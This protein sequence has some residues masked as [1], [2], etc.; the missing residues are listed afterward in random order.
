MA[1]QTHLSLIQDAIPLRYDMTPETVLARINCFKNNWQVTSLGTSRTFPHPLL[2]INKSGFVH[3][4]GVPKPLFGEPLTGVNNE[5][6][7]F[8]PGLFAGDFPV[9]FGISNLKDL[10]IIVK[11]SPWLSFTDVSINFV[12]TVIGLTVLKLV[13]YTYKIEKKYLL[14]SDLTRQRQKKTTTN[15]CSLNRS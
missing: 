15:R 1:V 6:F 7:R 3:P 11:T 5:F 13:R 2:V 12:L 9:W 10:S 14:M 8:L 4:L